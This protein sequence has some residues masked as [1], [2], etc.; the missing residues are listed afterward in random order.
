MKRKELNNYIAIMAATVMMLFQSCTSDIENNVQSIESQSTNDQIEVLANQYGDIYED[1]FFQIYQEYKSLAKDS[2]QIDKEKYSNHFINDYM[3]DLPK[4]QK[5]ILQ[6]DRFAFS[7]NADES[8]D[9]NKKFPEFIDSIKS[10]MF[11][12]NLD[13]L[14]EKICE[15][16]T[17]KDYLE[18]TVEERQFIKLQL[19]NLKKSR[20]IIASIIVEHY[21]DSFV[22]SRMSPGDRMVYSEAA[23]QMTDE[24]L[25]RT[26]SLGMQGISWVT[27]PVVGTIIAAVD[28][29]SALF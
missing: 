26:I 16:Y 10:I 28:F 1:I 2:I 14:N 4:E 23:S 29:I 19:L 5:A 12:A 24:E 15:F 20:D 25:D 21:K 9:I 7:R 27:V 22:Q 3:K 18:L 6:N 8:I 13:L 11:N 17:C